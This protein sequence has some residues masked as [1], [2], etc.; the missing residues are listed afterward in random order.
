LQELKNYTGGPTSDDDDDLTA[1]EI[2]NRFAVKSGL[3]LEDVVTNYA[4]YAD[5]IMRSF[6]AKG[7]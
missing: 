3:T 6:I 2:V 7:V 4:K 1:Q 5:E